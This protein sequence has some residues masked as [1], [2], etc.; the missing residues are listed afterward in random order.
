MVKTWC[1]RALDF[2]KN[3]L[4]NNAPKYLS[5]S[6]FLTDEERSLLLKQHKKERDGRKDRNFN[7]IFESAS[8]ALP[9]STSP[10]DKKREKPL[11]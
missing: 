9:Q 5:M 7:G 3:D 4:R 2:E 8:K 6:N 1:Q 10:K 11:S